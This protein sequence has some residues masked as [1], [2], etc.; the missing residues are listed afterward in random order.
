M[1][2][3][4]LSVPILNGN[5][6]KYVNEAVSAGW[7][8]TGGAFVPRLE[9]E[10]ADYA[11]V[12]DAA[13]VQSGTAALHL[14]M[15]ECGVGAGD[16]VIAP[17]LTFVAAVNPIKYVGAEPVFMDCDDSLCIDPDK[18]ECYLIEKCEERDGLLYDIALGK[19]IKAIVVVHI[20][21][22]MADME[23]IMELSECYC[24]PVIEDATEAV[25]TF[26]NYGRF[27]GCMAGTI[28]DYG[29]YSFNGNKIITTGGGGMFVARDAMRVQH[30]KH[31]A[32]QAKSDE[33]YY[34]H[35]EIGFNYRM[36]NVQAAIG[37][38]QLEQL[39]KFISTKQ[40]NY[41][42]YKKLGVELLPFDERVRPN[43][44]FYSHMTTERDKLMGHLNECN[45]Q[46]R[47]VWKLIHTLPM[48]KDCFVYMID[49]AYRYYDNIVNIPCS[50]NLSDED[51]KRISELIKN[52]G[53]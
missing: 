42:L 8:S 31:L 9:K 47:P 21:G 6:L 26:Y 30:A 25:G 20:F 27:N 19:P 10:F 3:I 37:V 51:V 17:T 4:P 18:L 32:T 45:I 41:F 1:E 46:T 2:F 16:I 22:N 36:T 5:E 43:Y 13:A 34:E 24:I 7:V 12:T 35:D 33:L 15:I 53:S 39:E 50:S 44:W 28:G 49:K 23:R 14:A 48:Y 38:A 40:E 29:A 52:N 11:G